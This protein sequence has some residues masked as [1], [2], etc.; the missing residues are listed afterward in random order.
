MTHRLKRATIAGLAGLAFLSAGDAFASCLCPKVDV[1]EVVQHATS[2]AVIRVV[3]AGA[4][5]SGCG[6][7]GQQACGIDV[8]VKVREYIKG[9]GPTQYEGRIANP[10]RYLCGFTVQAGDE[11]LDVEGDAPTLGKKTG[12]CVLHATLEDR[13]L[14]ER[15]KAAA[16]QQ[17]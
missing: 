4:V 16:G 5:R 8:V 11:L 13:S 15:F 14:I 10:D 9:T 12:I 17:R 6:G 3:A 7:A 2:I 1:N